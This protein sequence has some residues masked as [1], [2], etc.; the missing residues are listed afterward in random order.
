MNFFETS[1]HLYNEKF[2]QLEEYIESKNLPMEMREKVTEYYEQRYE[3]KMFD[4]N[5][6]LSE[7]SDNLRSVREI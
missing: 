5:S 1:T 6:I 4:E 2:K 7:L 3:G